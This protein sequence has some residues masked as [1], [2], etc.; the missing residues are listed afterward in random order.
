ML[1][2]KFFYECNIEACSSGKIL[3]N[4]YNLLQFTVHIRKILRIMVSKNVLLILVNYVS[5]LVMACWSQ[6][7]FFRKDH[8][9]ITT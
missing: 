2:T 3:E 9:H 6:I 8:T 5:T 4:F 7:T 1:R